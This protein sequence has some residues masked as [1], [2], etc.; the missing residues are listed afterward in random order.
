LAHPD[1]NPTTTN[2]PSHFNLC[3]IPPPNLCTPETVTPGASVAKVGQGPAQS[4][5]KV[6]AP[7]QSE[8]GLIDGDPEA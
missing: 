3:I 2:S 5:P 7:T 6:G 1:N 8:S 4:D